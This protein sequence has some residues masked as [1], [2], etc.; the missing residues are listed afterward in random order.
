MHPANDKS[1]HILNAS[2]NLL[3]ICFI[4]LTSLKLMDKSEKTVIDEVTIVAIV[5]LWPVAYC[6][7]YLCGKGGAANNWNRWLIIF[8][9]VD[10]CCSLL[11]PYFSR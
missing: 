11:L 6:R 5:F 2:S 9:W 7:F 1:P 3:G 8:S 10:C 4:V